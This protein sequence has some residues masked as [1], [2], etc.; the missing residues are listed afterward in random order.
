MK[1]LHQDHSPVQAIGHRHVFFNFPEDVEVNS[2]L[3]KAYPSFL[4]DLEQNGPLLL[5]RKDKPLPVYLTD[6][7]KEVGNKVSCVLANAET[8]G[9]ILTGYDGGIPNSGYLEDLQKKRE[10]RIVLTG[11]S[12]VG[13]TTTGKALVTPSWIRKGESLE[14]IKIPAPFELFYDVDIDGI[15]TKFL[16]SKPSG[17]LASDHLTKL[18]E[19]Y[20]L[21]ENIDA[22]VLDVISDTVLRLFNK[23]RLKKDKRNSLIGS[24]K[25]LLEQAKQLHKMRN[26]P[27]TSGGATKAIVSGIELIKSTIKGLSHIGLEENSELNQE[28]ILGL[29]KRTILGLG[30]VQDLNGIT[31]CEKFRTTYGQ[32][33]EETEKSCLRTVWNGNFFPTGDDKKNV[34]SGPPGSEIMSLDLDSIQESLKNSTRVALVLDNEADLRQAIDQAKEKPISVPEEMSMADVVIFRSILG[35]SFA[36]VIIKTSELRDKEKVSSAQEVWKNLVLDRLPNPQE[37]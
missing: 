3:K 15:K 11:P 26:E 21:P 23:V 9:Q 30:D 12:G 14:E 37:N 20:E 2:I 16:S 24:V 32:K 5:S 27:L 25:I 33:R 17:W 6:T 34:I 28:E 4:N 13:K 7:I 8:I 1:F 10:L 18:N 19:S 35:A 31:L 29:L 36:H 22:D